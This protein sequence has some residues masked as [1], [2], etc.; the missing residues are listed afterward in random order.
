MKSARWAVVPFGA[1]AVVALLEAFGSVA[2]YWMHPP[3]QFQPMFSE[4]NDSSLVFNIVV[5]P[6]LV[7]ARPRSEK[8]PSHGV[9]VLSHNPTMAVTLGIPPA[10]PI[11][12]IVQHMRR[13]RSNEL[14]KRGRAALKGPA[15]AA[16]PPCTSRA[17]APLPCEFRSQRL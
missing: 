1:V 9:F 6:P 17:S 12:S 2:R 11:S 15:K 13:S 14:S 4:F 3:M 8:Q 10:V 16:E 7:Q 5:L